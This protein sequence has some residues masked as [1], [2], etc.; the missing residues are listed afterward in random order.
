MSDARKRKPP[1]A[2]KGRKAGAP[3][4]TGPQQQRCRQHWADRV[5]RLNTGDELVLGWLN[6]GNIDGRC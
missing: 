1:N 5:R 3:N 2:S 4:K 6:E